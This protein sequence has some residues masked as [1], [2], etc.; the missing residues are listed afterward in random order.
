MNIPKHIAIIMDGNG[1]WARQRGLPRIMGHRAGTETVKKIVTSCVN[2]GVKHLTLYAF[3]TENWQR[4]KDE[5][6]GLFKLMED[7]LDREFDLL[8]KQDVR[9]RVIGERERIDSRLREKIEAQEKRSID[10][11]ALS[12][13]IAL[14][15]GGRQEIASAV[16]ALCRDAA[17]GRIKPEDINVEKFSEMLYTRGQPDPDLLIRTSGE[18]R[19][20]NFLLWQIAY[21]EMY[22]TEKLWPDF[23]EDD[24]KKAIEEYNRRER[25]FGK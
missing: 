11:K 2:L 3:S 8:Q 22:V 9:L 10:N 14:S 12:L 4:P 19:I 1:R 18:M 13:N 15:Y 20:S 23:T 6:T 25:R 17:E 16:R 7:F 24:L 21:S 5:V